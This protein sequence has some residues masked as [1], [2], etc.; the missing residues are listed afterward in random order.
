MVKALELLKKHAGC[1]QSVCDTLEEHLY[2][3]IQNGQH[4]SMRGPKLGASGSWESKL[5][6]AVGGYQKARDDNLPGTD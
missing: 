1:F 3:P 2:N 4:P 6:E 5:M